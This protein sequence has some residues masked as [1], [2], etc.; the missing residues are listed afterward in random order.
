VEIP[1]T[2][3]TGILNLTTLTGI[4]DI[5]TDEPDASSI[6]KKFEKL[7]IAS[8]EKE[9]RIYSDEQVTQLPVIESSHIH[10]GEWKVRRRSASRLINYLEKK[11]KPLAILEV[12]CGNGWFS[13]RLATI[14]NSSVTGIDINETEL[15]QAKRVFGD[16]TNI[17][18]DR[19]EIE[20]IPFGK[21]FEVIIFA[22]S[23]QYFPFLMETIGKALSILNQGGEIHI[24]DSPFYPIEDIA[25]AEQRSYLY[26]QSI[27]Y[28]ELAEFYFHH[29]I[30]SLSG[31]KHKILFDPFRMANKL[32]RR[33]DPFPWICIMAS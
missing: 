33:K 18:F 3:D 32:L 9:H 15:N 14:K 11:N 2:G 16:K 10:S 23:I 31:I 19:G 12:G 27:G 5:L 7:Y 21:N 28:G 6:S 30:D 20:N 22:A 25:N 8:R 26:Y 17:H 29:S 1:A 13:S 24:L 4:N